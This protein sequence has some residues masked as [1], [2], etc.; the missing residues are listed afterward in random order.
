M[1]ITETKI[2]K[3]FLAFYTNRLK[4]HQEM[5]VGIVSSDCQRLIALKQ[6]IS[7]FQAKIFD[8]SGQKNLQNNKLQNNRI[9]FIYRPGVN[10]G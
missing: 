6:T 4:M 5:G 10:K 2:W 3:K 1:G 9:T 8:V 7:I